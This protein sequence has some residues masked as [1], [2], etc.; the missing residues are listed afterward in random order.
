V[1][2]D[3]VVLSRLRINRCRQLVPNLQ[4]ITVWVPT[5]QIRFARAKLSLAENR[6]SGCFDS[7][8]G[9]LDVCAIDKTKGKMH[10]SSGASGQIWISLKHKHVAR[11]RGLRLNEVFVFIDR[12]R[13]EY[14][15]V[16]T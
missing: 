13:T 6:S 11:A 10:D 2:C 8:H 12:D 3:H 16:E 4:L 1:V 9:P 15:L 5:K 14:F 7:S